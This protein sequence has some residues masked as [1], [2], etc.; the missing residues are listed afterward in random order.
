MKGYTGTDCVRH[1]SWNTVT[2]PKGLG[3]GRVGEV[4]EELETV[5]RVEKHPDPMFLKYNT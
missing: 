3:Q 5:R 4:L 2:I 1:K